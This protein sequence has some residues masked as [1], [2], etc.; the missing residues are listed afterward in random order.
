MSGRIPG[1]SYGEPVVWLGVEAGGW[2]S[3]PTFVATRLRI[4]LRGLRPAP[5]GWCLLLGGATVHGRGLAA[6][7][8]V[9]G[10]S[11]G[12]CVGSAVELA[13]GGVVRIPGASAVLELPREQSLR[14]GTLIRGEPESALL[15]FHAVN[16]DQGVVLSVELELAHARR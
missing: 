4:R 2:R 13:P 10:V 12:G 3:P 1:P 14:D 7:I 5:F 15:A 9:V 8:L 11:R 16:P 6:P